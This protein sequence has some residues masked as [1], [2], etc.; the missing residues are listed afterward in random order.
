LQPEVLPQPSQTWQEPEG[1]IFVPQVMQMGASAARPCS[2][3]TRSADEVTSAGAS[4]SIAEL[5]FASEAAGCS[6]VGTVA[7][8]CAK[9][10]SSESV[11]ASLISSYM[12][13]SSWCSRSAAV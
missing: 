5:L 4:F 12:P 7:A 1:R 3:S 2:F 13:V 8:D 6:T 9:D 11:S 10:S